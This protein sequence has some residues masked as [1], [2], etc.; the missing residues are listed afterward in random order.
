M[1]DLEGEIFSVR[2]NL[3]LGD[4]VGGVLFIPLLVQPP[5]SSIHFWSYNSALGLHSG[6]LVF[7]VFLETL[8]GLSWKCVWEPRSSLPTL[9]ELYKSRSLL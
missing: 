3:S 2:I 5:P 6:I 9:F 8:L 1:L 4:F 7:W